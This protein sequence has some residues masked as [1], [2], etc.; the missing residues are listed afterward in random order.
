MK[1]NAVPMI[2]ASDC[3]S[4]GAWA[5]FIPARAKPESRFNGDRRGKLGAGL[6]RISCER[7]PVD[8]P[9]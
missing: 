8:E 6:R 1:S 9:D 7:S 4:S 2:A 3:F 5:I